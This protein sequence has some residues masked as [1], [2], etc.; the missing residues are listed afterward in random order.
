MTETSPVI[1]GLL[2]IHKIISRGLNISIRK[3]DD[4][5]ARK[6]APANEAK[7]FTLYVSTLKSVT[8]A[9]H[10]SE[11]EVAF[12]YFKEFIE[13]PYTNLS[14]DHQ[15]ISS[16]L[17]RMEQALPGISS[18]E[19]VK[20]REVLGDFEKLWVPHIKIEEEHFIA[21]KMKAG[22]TMK[23]QVGLVQKLA[24]HGS[25]NAGPGPLA[26]PFF[27]YNLEGRDREAFMRPFPVIVKKVLVPV[28]WKGQWKP[29]T[30]FL[31]EPKG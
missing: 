23:D 17:A 29:M 11:D 19:F 18:G 3:C 9:H 7:G 28:I 22:T 31:L 13:A 20:L 16:V 15:T 8:H 30:P 12:P 14:K 5:I 1:D 24:Q 2:M 4:Y 6:S 26:L 25:K 27:F 21:E 10:L